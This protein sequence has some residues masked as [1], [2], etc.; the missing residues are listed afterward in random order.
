MRSY[1]AASRAA[2]I[3]V[4]GELTRVISDAMMVSIMV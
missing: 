4:L 2:M 1:T 3:C